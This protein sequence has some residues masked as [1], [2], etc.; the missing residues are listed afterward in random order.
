MSKVEA[1]IQ[2]DVA[3]D[4]LDVLVHGTVSVDELDTEVALRLYK[5]VGALVLGYLGEPDGPSNLDNLGEDLN[6]L[7]VELRDTHALDWEVKL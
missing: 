6:E 7:A 5:F 1:A 4:L 3:L 2:S